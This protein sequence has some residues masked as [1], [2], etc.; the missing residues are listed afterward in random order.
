MLTTLEAQL[1]HTLRGHRGAIGRIAWSP[2]GGMIASPSKDGSIRLWNAHSGDLIW[3]SPDAQ[4]GSVYCVAWSS[5]GQTLASGYRSGTICLW[6]AK[7]GELLCKLEGHTDRVF[8]ASWLPQKAVLASGSADRSIRL[9]DT[10]SRRQIL[11]H[12]AHDSGVNDLAW[13]S[14]GRRLASGSNDQHTRMWDAEGLHLHWKRLIWDE[15]G[16][17]GGV[18]SL[19]WSPDGSM[20]ATGSIDKTIVIRNPDRGTRK[21][22]LEGHTGVVTGVTFSADSKLLASKSQD[23]TVRLWRC[24]NWEIPAI[25]EESNS[26]WW[27]AGLAFPPQTMTLATLG[28]QDTVI[29]IW[30]LASG[31][32]PVSP[33]VHHITA[34]IVLVGDSGVGKTGL[35]WRFA[36]KKFREQS[37]T[38]GQQFWVVEELGIRRADGTDCEAVLWDLAGQHVYRPIHAIFLDNVDAS[39]ILFDPTNRQDPLKGAQFWLE[40]LKGKDR[41][42]PSVLVGARIDRGAPV[43]T[44]QELEQFCQHYGISGGFVG[45]SA[46]TGEGLAQLL[47]ILK[48]LIPWEHMTATVTTRTF[49]RIKDYVKALKE[50]TDRKRVLVRPAELRQ[51]LQATDKDW[52]F[53]DDEMMTAAGHLQNHGYVTILRSSSGEVHILLTP[54]L[55]VSVASSIVLQADRHPRE[56]GAIKETELLQGKYAF[57]ELRELEQSEQQILLDAAVLRFLEHSVCFRETLGNDTLLIFPGLIKQKRP[58]EDDLPS[59]DDISYI[60][61]GRVENIYAML[62]VDLGYTQSFTLINQWQNQAQYELHTGEICG[63][64]MLEEREGEI[65]LVLYY[66]DRMPQRGR[67]SFQELFEK[68]L[69]QREVDVTRFPPVICPKGHRQERASVI[70]RVREGKTF[71]FCD[72]CGNK[73]DLPEINKPGIG[74]SASVWLQ[75]EEASALLRST[76]EA[77]LLRVKGYRRQ[78]AAP[79]CYLS[80]LP[81]QTKWAEKLIHDLNEAGVFVID[82]AFQA[83]LGDWVLVLDTP[84]YEQAF[85]TSAEALKEDVK[86]IKARLGGDKGRLISIVPEGKSSSAPPHDLR[87]CIPGNFCDETHYPVSLFDLVLNLYAIPFDHSGF[88]PLR[89]SLHQQ[90]EQAPRTT[91][92]QDSDKASKK[93]ESKTQAKG[94]IL[95]PEH[96][97]DFDLHIAPNGHAIA[98]SPEGQATA[99][100]SIQVP[101][102]I[103]LSLNLLETRQTNAALIKQLGQELYGWLFPGDIHTH[104]HQT[105]AHARSEKAKIRLRLRVEAEKIASLPLEFLYRTQGGYFLAVN[106]GTVLSRYLNLPLPPGRVRRREPPLHMLAIIADPSDQTRLPP[107]EWEAII[108]DALS[109]PLANGQMNLQTVKRATRKEIRHALLRQKPDIIQ[110]VGHGIYKSGKGNLA[111][112]DEETGKTWLVDD[113]RFT[114]LYLGHEDNLG[115]IS[116]A[117]CESAK[118]DDPQGFLGIAPQLI[119]RGVPAVLSM[120]YKVLIK[121]AKIFL[122]DFYTYV[123]ARKPLDWATQAARNAVSQELGLDNREFGTPVLYMRAE[124]GNVF[125]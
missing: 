11:S 120:Q 15:H 121:T 51:Q 119:Q 9:W 125:W 28:E 71:A 65:E 55:L 106:P 74:T 93:E 17:A 2:E 37:S 99:D 109:G 96:Y 118:S 18:T 95:M 30:N 63:F 82:T 116:L 43:I 20:L 90:W 78:C 89:K 77:H 114:N 5:D 8:C 111:L 64:R 75:R 21:V 110:F 45:T 83:Q 87:S 124:D 84:A 57:D 56:L 100:I 88:A 6:N 85:Q 31:V 3:T 7:V 13:S 80:H 92:T 91:H 36:H 48:A 47:E 107:D 86:I 1:R 42:P 59:T 54:D 35:G 102:A 67:E 122:E 97:I 98:N 79:R 69:Y 76:Y 53:T 24:N 25:L 10:E 73:T 16:H 22:V 40:Q 72:E 49:K 62:V 94:D 46:M 44:Q 32:D 117:T 81:E 12:S 19:A 61:R 103:Q 41:L 101:N 26:D 115:L 113:E 33:S 60:V 23:G 14:D 66:G 68:F 50:K 108:K 29:R 34:K 38:H 104:F 70:K 105:E 52:Q 112:V 4:L 123:A 58:L 27:A 39:L